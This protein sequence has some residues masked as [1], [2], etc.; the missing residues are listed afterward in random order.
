MKQTG[1]K[2]KATLLRKVIVSLALV[3]MA[4]GAPVAASADNTPPDNVSK[5]A[6]KAMAGPYSLARVGWGGCGGCGQ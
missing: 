3:G 1:S 4:V 6:K 2:K 5:V